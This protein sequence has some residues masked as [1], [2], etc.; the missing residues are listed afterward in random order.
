[1]RVWPGTGPR[2]APAVCSPRMD[3]FRAARPPGHASRFSADA[4]DPSTWAPGSRR[5]AAAMPHP[6]GRWTM[7]HKVDSG[8]PATGPGIPAHCIGHRQPEPAAAGGA[9]TESPSR[10]PLACLH[11]R[12]AQAPLKQPVS[13][14]QAMAVIRRSAAPCGRPP[15]SGASAVSRCRAGM[16]GIPGTVASSPAVPRLIR[17]QSRATDRRQRRGHAP[18]RPA[19]PTIAAG[20]HGIGEN[21]EVDR[22]PEP[23]GPAA[24]DRPPRSTLPARCRPIRATDG[25]RGNPGYCS[26]ARGRRRRSAAP[27]APSRACCTSRRRA[28]PGARSRR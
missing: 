20:H 12:L 10:R 9:V 8:P 28:P 24:A 26:V 16:C 6:P 18:S 13:G 7:P 17:H 22:M 14:T 15:V 2:T 5:Q 4:R 27:N 25:R 19:F 21:A 23:C 1:M 3:S 11:H